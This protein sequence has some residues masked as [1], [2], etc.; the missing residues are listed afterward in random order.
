AVWFGTMFVVGAV[1][2]RLEHYRT[3][4]EVLERNV[5]VQLW[6]RLAAVKA[7]EQFAPDIS[8]A[9]QLRSGGSFLADV[10]AATDR[11]APRILGIPVPALEPTIDAGPLAWFAG[12]WRR[13]GTPVEALDLPAGCAWDPGWLDRLD[14][15]WT[16]P[17]GRLRLAATAG[18]HDTLL[19]AGTP[20]EA[21]AAAARQEA[22]YQIL[23]F[24]VWVPLVLGVAWLALSRLLVPLAEI[25]ATAH[26]I[27]AGRFDDRIDV[28]RTESEFAEMAGM[29]NDM[30]DRLEE[31][32][33]S[34]SR[35]NADVAHQLMNP[36]HAIQ[37]EADAAAARPRT[38]D[39]LAASL[40]RVGGLSRR[41]ESICGALLAYARSAALD[42]ARL[43]S[44]DLEPIISAACD[45]V[46][47]LASGRGIAIIPPPAGMVVKGDAALLEEVFVNLLVNAVEH[48]GP[49]DQIEIVVGHDA[50]GC[51]AAVIDH[52]AGVPE[53]A[54]PELFTRF[55]SGKP[56]GHG[57]GLA[58]S[59]RILRSHSGDL[60]HELT[61]GGGATFIL[62]FPPLA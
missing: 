37:L 8:L 62:R 59:R 31:I 41:I 6:S 24:V 9:R 54:I 7:A 57:V 3:T 58:L 29:L 18:L 45:R 55:R 34:Q 20:L 44:I 15:L 21:V 16:T 60:G 28:R 36:V 43:R 19:V 52:G 14:S 61:P 46:A 30:L 40:E 5:D 33:L 2:L 42:K 35:F 10:P 38:T 39:E 11:T 26:R 4:V 53:A 13:D 23:T 25:A 51:R 32:R 56:A 17:D 50:S 27:R 1:A 48:S 49:G 22:R 12:V 47:D